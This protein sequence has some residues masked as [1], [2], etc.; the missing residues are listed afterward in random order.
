MSQVV[1]VTGR[2]VTTYAAALQAGFLGWSP[3][4][5]TGDTPPSGPTI[6][7]RAAAEVHHP[8]DRAKQYR[9]S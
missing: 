7:G 9:R 8:T 5:S 2:E 3:V 1:A 6:R 4:P